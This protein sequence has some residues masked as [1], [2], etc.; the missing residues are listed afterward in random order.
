[1]GGG[2]QSYRIGRKLD[3]AASILP[4]LTRP[5][6]QFSNCPTV[7]KWGRCVSDY[8][9]C[10]MCKLSPVV[11]NFHFLRGDCLLGPIR[12]LADASHL[13][14][15]PPIMRVPLLAEASAT[16]CTPCRLCRGIRKP[17]WQRNVQHVANLCLSFSPKQTIFQP[18]SSP[19]LNG[20]VQ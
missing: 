12:R 14:E 13:Q 6:T 10:K 20:S 18:H 4:S 8:A 2:K 5:K 16:K 17:L 9:E 15:E 3:V 11:Q 19:S 1:M 7:R